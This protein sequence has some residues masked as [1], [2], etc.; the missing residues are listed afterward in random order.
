MKLELRLDIEVEEM[1]SVQEM[2]SEIMTSVLNWMHTP[3]ILAKLNEFSE[4]K[5]LQDCSDV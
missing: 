2:R 5:M 1:V 4:V 3:E